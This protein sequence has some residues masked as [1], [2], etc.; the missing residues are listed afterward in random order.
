MA[1]RFRL[2]EILKAR[3]MSRSD[4]ARRSDVSF[5]TINRMAANHAVQISLGT[6]DRLSAAQG[7]EPGERLEQEPEPKRRGQ[8]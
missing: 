2:H 8:G 6:L 7:V 5:T 4:L 3:G 1:A